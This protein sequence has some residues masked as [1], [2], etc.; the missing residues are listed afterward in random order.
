MQI[1]VPANVDSVD[2]ALVLMGGQTVVGRA[3]N[4]VGCRL[5]R[6]GGGD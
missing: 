6:R 4:E 2:K 1:D 5:K 3:F